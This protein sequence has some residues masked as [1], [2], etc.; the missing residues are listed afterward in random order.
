METRRVL[1]IGHHRQTEASC[2]GVKSSN[3]P[4]KK[5]PNEIP[6]HAVTYEDIDGI[7]ETNELGT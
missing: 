2:R 4:P 6:N 3:P 7:M 5:A 1:G